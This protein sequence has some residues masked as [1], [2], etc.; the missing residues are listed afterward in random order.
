MAA[1]A[2]AR[3]GD[4][5][6]VRRIDSQR[7]FEQAI[8]EMRAHLDAQNAETAIALADEVE[9]HELLC[10]Q[11]AAVTLTEAGH[12]LRSTQPLERAVELWTE[13][14]ARAGEEKVAYN[15]GNAELN[16]FEAVAARHGVAAA[17]AERLPLL[18]EA[19]AHFHLAAETSLDP[20]DRVQAW[21]DLGNSFDRLGRDVE[22]IDAYRQ[23][24][25]IDPAFGMAHGNL[26]IALLGVARFA[27]ASEDLC[28]RLVVSCKSVFEVG[29]ERG[30]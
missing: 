20:S 13:I 7:S 24:L 10:A 18:Q 16:L 22:A 15:R 8:S 30:E 11:F 25:A 2:F 4:E 5:E 28:T 17:I 12:A 27:G 26:G 19:R 21:T 23:A 9:G 1:G 3:V 29:V 6:A 14:G